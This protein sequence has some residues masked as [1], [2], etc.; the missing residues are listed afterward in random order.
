MPA[1][2]GWNPEQYLRFAD[3]RLQPVIDLIARIS[4]HGPRRVVDLGCG[5][6]NALQLLSLRFPGAEVTGVDGSAEMLGKAARS[7]YRTEQADIAT[8]RPEEPVD[9]IF[10]NAALHWLPEH[11]T[12]F[13]HLL[14]LLSPGGVLAVQMPAMDRMPLRQLQYEVARHG[15]WADAL[16]GV[17]SARGLL[18]IQDYYRML[19]PRSVGLEL[20]FT[21]YV[22]VLKGPDPVVQWAMGSSLR[23]FLDVLPEEM[24]PDFLAAYAEALRP[25]YPPLEDGTVLLPFRRFFVLA[26]I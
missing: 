26:S 3:E 1:N 4:H 14:S 15:P 16:K 6:G 9:V 12:L 22:H 7:G 23:P 2:P 21:E 5:A 20:W 8:W 10:S 18:P 25:H 11:E 13:P 19:R 17:S 24:K